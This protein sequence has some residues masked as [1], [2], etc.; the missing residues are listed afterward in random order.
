M[1]KDKIFPSKVMVIGFSGSGKS[2]ISKMISDI[3]NIPVLYLDTVH[4]LP[5]WIENDKETEYKII[6]DFLNDNDS[7]VID[8]N[9]SHMS[10][11]ER[12]EKSDLIVFMSF[13]RFNCLFR[14]FK[15]L[16]ENRGKTRES[17]TD[18]CVEKVDFEFIKWILFDSRKKSQTDNYKY[19]LEKYSD[20]VVIIRN[21]KEYDDF[22]DILRVYK[23]FSV[24]KPSMA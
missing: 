5:N 15:R 6:S 16:F 13:N 11:K 8:G 18:N 22:I 7:W 17:M 10:Y 3:L 21:Q 14:A 12:L 24:N 1:P 9:Y 19:A 23:I 2:T 4:W 20:K